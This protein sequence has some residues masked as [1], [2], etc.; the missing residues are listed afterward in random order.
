MRNRFIP[1]IFAVAVVLAISVQPLSA[2]AKPA[3]PD[4]NPKNLSGVWQHDVRQDPRFR[5][6]KEPLPM[7]PWAEAKY[8]YQM[9]AEGPDGRGRDEL[10]P[11]YKCFPRGPTAAWQSQEYPFEIIQ[12]PERTMIIYEWNNEIRRI[13]TDGRGHQED[14]V[15]SWYG[16]SIGKWE[17]DALVID[18]IGLNDLTW[19]DRTGHVHSTAMHLTERLRRDGPN[20]LVLDI[21]VDDPKAYTKP[22]TA[23]L[24]FVRSDLELADHLGCEDLLINGKLVP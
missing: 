11:D 1:S 12:T 18:T 7:Q 24:H 19:L 22:F 2:Q 16:D 20:R 5:L 17:G 4:N 13:W 14:P 15:P 21:T 9:N 6:S 23:T 10:H 3:A 8:K